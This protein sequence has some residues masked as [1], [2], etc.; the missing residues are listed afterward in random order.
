MVRWVFESETATITP[1]SRIRLPDAS[2]LLPPTLARQMLQGV[3]PDELSRIPGT[4]DRRSRGPGSATDPRRTGE[5]GGPG[6]H[7]GRPGSGLPV[8]VE[9][10]AEGDR[11]PVVST[12]LGELSLETPPPELTDFRPAPDITIN[13]EESVD[14]A[15]AANAF[16]PY[17]LPATLAGPDHPRRRGSRARSASTA[18]A[19]RP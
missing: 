4:P 15:A 5:H 11:R 6:G 8:Q 14:V 1:V 3:R 12:T 16:A 7:L 19:R 13:Y 9:L 2:D 18:A 17:D 10:Y